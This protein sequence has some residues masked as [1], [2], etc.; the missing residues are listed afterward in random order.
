MARWDLV[1]HMRL[2]GFPEMANRNVIKCNCDL[3]YKL[4]SYSWLVEGQYESLSDTSV[5]RFVSGSK[6]DSEF[7]RRADV[8]GKSTLTSKHHQA[9]IIAFGEERF[10][11]ISGLYSSQINELSSG[12]I[13]DEVQ[14]TPSMFVTFIHETDLPVKLGLD[15]LY[16]YENITAT[17][18]GTPNYVGHNYTDVARAFESVRAFRLKKSHMADS[19]IC[20]R[21][22]AGLMLESTTDPL[23]YGAST[24]SAFLECLYYSECEQAIEYVIMSSMSWSPKH[25]FIE[26]YQAIEMLFKLVYVHEF[27]KRVNYTNKSY[28]LIR[29]IEEYLAWRIT[30]RQAIIKL[31]KSLPSHVLEL[32]GACRKSLDR[33]STKVAEWVYEVRCSH[34]H[35]G[36]LGR[37]EDLSDAQWDTLIHATVRAVTYLHSVYQEE[38][39]GRR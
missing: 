20:R 22:Q 16:I 24:K 5:K 31:F 18:S 13:I 35:A 26:L 15:E 37:T 25:C 34:V 21:L 19:A 12:Y 1:N 36:L 14:L 38:L 29:D 32:F 9:L 6:E 4:V 17:H 7:V 8:T 3:F 11:V 39:P 10:F 27:A 30:E 28:E 33:N 2:S 23:P